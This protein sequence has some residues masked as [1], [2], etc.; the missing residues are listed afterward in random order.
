MNGVA[1]QIFTFLG[2]FVGLAVLAVILSKNSNTTSVLSSTFGGVAQDIGAAVS[3]ITG[4]G[5]SGVSS[6]GGGNLYNL[7]I[8]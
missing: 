6:L 1:T 4:A 8:G 5:A 2:L 7:G 3:P